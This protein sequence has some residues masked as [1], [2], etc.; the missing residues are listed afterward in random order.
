M[1]HQSVVY[2][3]VS[4]AFTAAS[5]YA[6][7]NTPDLRSR[8][9]LSLNATLAP[10]WQVAGPCMVLNDASNLNGVQWDIPF[11]TPEACTTYCSTAS[12]DNYTY[13]AVGGPRGGVLLWV[14]QRL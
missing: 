10:G 11:N 13:A 4:T 2:A 14:R 12:M 7:P 8:N 1:T 9:L 5:I 3:V 6:L